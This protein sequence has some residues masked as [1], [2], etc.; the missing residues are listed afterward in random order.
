[1]KRK[2]RF[3]INTDAG[4]VEYNVAFFNRSNGTSDGASIGLA[5][6]K[7]DKQNFIDKFGQDEYDMFV[8]MKDRLKNNNISTDIVYHTSHTSKEE[9]SKILNDVSSRVVKNKET[10]KNVNNVKVAYEDNQWIIYDVL[11]WETAMNLGDGTGWCITG[12]YKTNGKVKPSQ[13]EHYFNKYLGSY[14]SMYLFV[15]NKATGKAE[16]CICPIQDDS[17]MNVWNKKDDNIGYTDK[18]PYF[19]YNGFKYFNKNE[20]KV[21]DGKLV[22]KASYELES[23]EIPDGVEKIPSDVFSYS[24]NLKSIKI[25]DSVTSIDFEAFKGCE[26]LDNVILPRNLTFLGNG[27]FSQC[28]S[29]TKIVIPDG[30]EEIDFNV[31]SNCKSLREVEFP[32]SLKSIEY[33]A[34]ANCSSLEKIILPDSVELLDSM[35]FMGCTSLKK[36]FIPK[37]VSKVRVDAFY[38]CKNLTIYCEAE[39]KPSKWRRGWNP[40]DRPVVWGCT[41]EKYLKESLNESKEDRKKFID[42]FGEDSYEVFKKSN[43]MLKKYRISTDLT[44]HVKNT[45]VEEMGELVNEL[46]DEVKTE[47]IMDSQGKP[48]MNVE[49]AFEDDKWLIYD[50]RDWQTAVNLGEGTV[51]CITG[52]YDTH[53]KVKYSQAKAYFT[54]YLDDYYSMYLFAIDK[55]TNEAKYCICP[56]MEKTNQTVWDKDDH[57]LYYVEE[58]PNFEYKGFEY[59]SNL[60]EFANERIDKFKE[61]Y[62]LNDAN[63]SL[64]STNY[65]NLIATLD[66]V[67]FRLS[68]YDYPWNI[69]LDFIY[70]KKHPFGKEVLDFMRKLT[71]NDFDKMRRIYLDSVEHYY[72]P[73]SYTSNNFAYSDVMRKGKWVTHVEKALRIAL[74]GG[75]VDKYVNDVYEDEY[76]RPARE[77]ANESLDSSLEEKIEIHDTLNPS[78]WENDELKPEVKEKIEEVVDKF[79]EMLE[80]RDIKIKV[81]DILILG[82]NASYNYNKHSD[83]DVHIISDTDI[84]KCPYE[85]LLKIYDAYRSL[86]NNKYDVMIN[87]SEIELYVESEE[88]DA[89]SNGIYSLNDGWIKKPSKEKI[90][91]VDITKEVKEW[92]DRY[93]ELMKEI[94]ED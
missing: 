59:K 61:I 78:L 29:L 25:P 83:I 34:F 40:D 4:N 30:I 13:A 7:E 47:K 93:S 26:K 80:E 36:V 86:F 6:S 75:D 32:K 9:M 45:S 35:I 2:K 19:E 46:E 22:G 90:K 82:S 10:G 52:R 94:S 23:Y 15:I 17:Y 24:K 56:N 60:D 31:F 63:I 58:I 20:L 48:H 66:N 44:W 27:A 50:V 28:K 62:D 72:V 81:N 3:S 68:T 85:H 49:K 70:F 77:R 12:R 38:G 88:T 92:E 79:V 42:K 16:Y 65:E 18:I 84:E 5:E 21:V 55:K 37:G 73:W 53:G 41:R 76:V 89:K 57:K 51:W 64:K 74:D 54:S 67:D 91:D 43:S 87:G 71:N 69:Y 14:Y 39:S 1:M 8:K 33:R 11:D